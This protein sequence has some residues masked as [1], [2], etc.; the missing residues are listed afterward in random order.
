MEQIVNTLIL[1]FGG[2]FFAYMLVVVTRIVHLIKP[3][4]RKYDEVIEY[5]KKYMVDKKLP[6]VLQDRLLTYYEYTFEKRY[7]R[8]KAIMATLSE[9]L[10][11]EIM[12]F[13]CMKMMNLVEIFD[14]M[15]PNIKGKRTP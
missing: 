1:I 13:N 15:P 9:H 14:N 5:L 4:M 6:E 10:K 7:F 3:D 8:E 12:L 2:L 11:C